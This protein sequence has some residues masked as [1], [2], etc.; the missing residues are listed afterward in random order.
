MEYS[1]CTRLYWMAQVSDLIS[2]ITVC[3]H[4]AVAVRRQRRLSLRKSSLP[5]AA[6]AEDVGEW[7]PIC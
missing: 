6:D 5:G 4:D 3:E 2:S 7:R 1:K